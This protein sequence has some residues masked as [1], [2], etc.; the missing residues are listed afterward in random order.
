MTRK[1]VIV[2][3]DYCGIGNVALKM[4]TFALMANGIEVIGVPTK[5][6]S[7]PMNNPFYVE[8]PINHFDDFVN[9]VAL[10]NDRCDGVLVGLLGS[11]QVFDGTLE[12]IK[13][14]GK[15]KMILDPILGDNG[16]R[17]SG[18]KDVYIEFYREIIKYSKLVIPNI[19]EAILLT[20]GNLED[21]KYYDDAVIEKLIDGLVKLGANRIL[22]KGE[23]ENGE[24][25]NRYFDG[26]EI[27]KISSKFVKKKFHGTGD[28][29]AGLLTAISVKDELTKD[30]IKK[31]QD[32]ISRIIENA[33][34][35]EEILP[36]CTDLQL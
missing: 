5:L 35:D 25:V 27:H 8:L 26:S 19:T 23:N 9:S 33:A 17:Y 14:Y 34:M 12:F 3:N 1:K 13:K 11:E 7:S 10:I 21:C 2:F 24:F 29:I 15:G 30:N 20:G 31:A 18:T 16:A 6:F 4:N 36:G 22:L 28:L 32:M